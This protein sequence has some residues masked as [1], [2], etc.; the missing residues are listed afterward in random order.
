VLRFLFTRRWLGLLLAVAIVAFGCVELGLWQFRRYVDRNSVNA[1]I[2]ANLSAAPVPVSHLMRTTAPPAAAD[3]WRVATAHGTYDSAHQVAVLYRTRNGSPGVDLV[4]PLRTSTGPALV[5]D[6]GWVA[7]RGGVESTASL[8]P[9]PRGPVT[10]TGWVR[11]NADGGSDQTTPHGRAVRA[12]SSDALKATVPYPLYDGFLDATSQ[13]PAGTPA[14]AAALAPDLS[15]GP[16][17]FYGLQW[18]FF[19]LLALGFYGYF[20]WTEYQRTLRPASRTV[21]QRTRQ[22]TVHGQHRTGDVASGR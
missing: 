13:Q 5:V 10:V 4:V 19:A 9:P 2:T 7:T 16:H 18:F 1:Q 11:L 14:P 3:E 6:R 12:I 22:S 15:S 17:F 21:S 8:P 20:A